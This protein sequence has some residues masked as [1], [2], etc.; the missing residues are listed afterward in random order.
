MS[1]N[2]LHA[3]ETM[4]GDTEILAGVIDVEELD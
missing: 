1:W 3:L 2:V 4:L